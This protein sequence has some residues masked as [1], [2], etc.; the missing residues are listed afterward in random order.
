MNRGSVDRTRGAATIGAGLSAN[1]CAMPPG[2]V[3][4]LHP[5]MFVLQIL[6]LGL[7]LAVARLFLIEQTYGFY[8]L[9]PV[10]FG[11]FIVHAWL[12]A[13]WRGWFFV[14]LFPV[15][16]IAMLGVIPG[17]TLMTLGIGL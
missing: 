3:A 13:R 14:L 1:G 8:R 5:R 15:C 6:Q 11:G 9:I 17:M 7:V 16:S 4:P 10:I 12:P 2:R